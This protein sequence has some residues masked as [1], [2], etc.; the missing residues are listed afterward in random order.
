M[1]VALLVGVVLQSGSS[2]AS[3]MQDS[4]AREATRIATERATRPAPRAN[5][6]AARR[7]RPSRKEV[8]AEDLATVFKDATSKTLL[9]RARVARLSQDSA[10]ISY[11]VNSYQ[12]ISAGIGFTK[13]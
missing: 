3:R 13:L 7:S 8:T 2:Q 11:D 9:D 10:L 12:R 1:L 5:Q 4:I 6:Q